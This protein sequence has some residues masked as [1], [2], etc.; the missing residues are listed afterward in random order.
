MKNRFWIISILLFVA[1]TALFSASCSSGEDPGNYD[2]VSYEKTGGTLVQ[3]S[4]IDEGDIVKTYGNTAYKLQS[5]GLTVYELNDEN[6]TLKAFYEFTSQRNVPVEMHVYKNKVLLVYGKRKAVDSD[7]YLESGYMGSDADY[8]K[9]CIDV[10]TLP[11]DLTTRETAFDLSDS[12]NYTFSL[13]G[14]VITSRLYVDTG[15]SYFVFSADREFS[16]SD[17]V[18]ANNPISINYTENGV[19][20]T[21]DNL[22]VIP[23]VTETTVKYPTVLFKLN[24]SSDTPKSTMNAVYGS[25]LQDVYM[26]DTSIIP[27]FCSLK[28][29]RKRRGFGCYAYSYPVRKYTTYCLLL[30]PETMK[31]IDG[32]TLLD[33]RL[34]NRRAV[35]DYGDVIYITATKTDGSGTTIIALDAKK[36]SQLNKLD[37]IAPDENVKSVA[38]AEENGKRYCYITTF[39]QIDPLFKVDITDPLRMQTLGSIEMPGFSTFMLPVG[40]KLLTLGYDDN[41][42]QGITST[43]KIALYDASGQGLEPIDE[44]IIKNVIYCEAIDDPRVI[45]V[46]GTRFAFSLTRGDSLTAWKSITQALYVFDVNSGEI[47]NIGIVSEFRKDNENGNFYIGKVASGDKVFDTTLFGKTA[48]CIRR[49]RIVGNYLYTFSDATISSYELGE[50][51]VSERLERVYTLFEGENGLYYGN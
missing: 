28:Y 18:I 17:D 6:V 33:Y 38:Y 36:F 26:S 1:V 40:D 3:E 7:G 41:G 5:D 45:A 47:E 2:D 43:V 29:E 14:R 23:G 27:I 35:K 50:N 15:I 20:K 30:S 31:I 13:N 19:S 4:G 42:S 44:R 48:Y 9:T 21:F 25:E 11:D 46:S 49:A 12:V 8:S 37:K 16:S 10:V 24:L 22:S 51:S 34:Y 39:L 32:V